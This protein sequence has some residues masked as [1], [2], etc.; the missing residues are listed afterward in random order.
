VAGHVLIIRIRPPL[1][2]ALCD[3]L[4][5][6]A[7]T[8]TFRA[9]ILALRSCSCSSQSGRLRLRCRLRQGDCSQFV[10]LLLAAKHRCCRTKTRICKSATTEGLASAANATATASAAVNVAIAPAAI[11]AASQID[12]RS[13]RGAAP[14]AAGVR[15]RWPRVQEAA[16]RHPAL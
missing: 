10:F 5:L 16:A 13:Q 12:R 6:S 7:L 2:V 3:L 8:F 15:R 1:L 4:T 11:S 9:L 14:A